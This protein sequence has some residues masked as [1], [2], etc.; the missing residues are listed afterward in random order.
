MFRRSRILL[1]ACLLLSASGTAFAQSSAP[2]SRPNRSG[3]PNE[4]YR[5]PST[6]Q[7]KTILVPIGTTW[8]GRIDQTISSAHSHSGTAFNIVMSSPV[9]LNGTEVVVPAGSS[10]LG[11][12][13]EAM[14]ASHVPHPPYVDKR[15]VKG[16]L[17]ISI[18]GLRTPDGVTHPLV[19]SVAGEVD[20][21]GYNGDY[22]RSPLGTSVGYVGS[23]S[24]FEAVHPSRARTS[25]GDSQDRRP[26]VIT[27]RDL[28]NDPI[29]G[30]GEDGYRNDKLQIRS[31]V[32]NH[33]DYYIYEG[34]PITVR[35]QAPFKMSVAPPAI[36]PL[37]NVQEIDDQLPPPTR[38]SAG[39]FGG[40]G[41]DAGGGGDFGGGG[42]SRPS[43]GGGGT[44]APPQNSVP[45]DGF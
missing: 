18:S 36:A 40:G 8:E 44:Y 31:L 29:L 16:K 35:L 25:R 1:A 3:D 19:A 28:L 38:A 10:I 5:A 14:P 27:K 30:A 4:F 9:L 2:P 24:S 22:I 42:P 20:K 39:G 33:R 32:V 17:R 7:G 41:R 23:S 26:P 37:G 13:V 43:N 34:S 12:V 45:S 15:L 21:S 6:V 11:E